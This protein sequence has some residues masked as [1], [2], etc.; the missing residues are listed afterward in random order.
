MR[1]SHPLP[2]SGLCEVRRDKEEAVRDVGGGRGGVGCE[3]TR[4]L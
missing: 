1:H 2:L 3:G 4:K